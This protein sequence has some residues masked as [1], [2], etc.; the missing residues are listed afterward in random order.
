VMRLL[1]QG[2]S[3]RD[4]ATKLKLAISTIDNHKARLMKKLNIHKASDLT[5]IAVREGF[6][7]P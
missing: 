1:A 5:R 3:V 6:I 4:C 7:V 2:M